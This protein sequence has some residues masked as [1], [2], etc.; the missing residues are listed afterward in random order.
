MLMCM[1]L[2]LN[3]AFIKSDVHKLRKAI[4]LCKLVFKTFLKFLGVNA[5]ISKLEVENILVI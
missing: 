5:I 2:Q 1:V 4:A 3:F